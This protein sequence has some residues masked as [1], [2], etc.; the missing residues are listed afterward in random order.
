MKDGDLL[1]MN[2]NLLLLE[3]AVAAA[4]RLH[5]EAEKARRFAYLRALDLLILGR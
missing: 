1:V 4:D 2:H 5:Y 3:Q